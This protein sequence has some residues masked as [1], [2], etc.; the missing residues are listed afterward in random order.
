MCVRHAHVCMQP[1]MFCAACEFHQH[2]CL[3][4]WQETP[5]ENLNYAFDVAEKHL[6]IPK[7]LDAEGQL[8]FFER[9]ANDILLLYVEQEFL[10]LTW[11]TA[12]K[13]STIYTQPFLNFA[14]KAK[15]KDPCKL[16]VFWIH[17]N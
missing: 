15:W 10:K 12:H 4:Y 8:A 7:M 6:D 11:F 14:M 5:L 9:K 1:T 3:S 17:G 13:I 2:Q 16:W